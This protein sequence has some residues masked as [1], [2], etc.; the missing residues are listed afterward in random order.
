MNVCIFGLG[1]IGLPIAL[2]CADS[3]HK[4]VGIDVNEILINT[5]KKGEMAFDEPE[6]KELLSK[7]LNKNFFPK[8]Q[9]KDDVSSDLKQAEYIM[10][11]VG[12]GFA[13]YPDKL[14]LS[15][16]Y[17]IVDQITAT[18]VNGKTIILRVTLPIGTSDEIKN[19]I[20]KKTGLKE[21]KDFWFSF[22]PERI[23]EGKAIREERSLPKIVGCYS[24]EGFLKVSTF[25]KK[26][27]G[28]IVRVSNPRTA[29]F[30]KLIDNSWRNTRFAFANE[31]AFLAEENGIDVM[32]AIA[33]A[34]AGYERNEIPRPGPVSGYCLGK[35]PYL[36]E[37]AFEKIAKR[38]GFDSMWYYGRRANDWF[39]EKVVEEVKGKNVL[40]AGLSFKEN[41][42]DYR[43]SHGIEI[44]R[45]LLSKGCKVVVC[46]PFLNKNYY[47]KL[48]EDIANKAKGFNTIEEA[49][50]S[51]IDTV[52]F[53][54]RHQ[55]YQKLDLEKLFKN[56]KISDVTVIDLWNMFTKTSKNITIKRLGNGVR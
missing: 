17:S 31:L 56:K 26:I 36:L 24:D 32:E 46:D 10:L 34:N 3:G 19:L 47:T 35:D 21:G 8:N 16:L 50:T 30:I 28:D 53:T 45:M 39:N 1:R 15:T 55:E 7:H 9:N 5:I 25:F 13:K 29:E 43:Y 40:I 11:A 22:V 42:D 41:I 54:T 18:G 48:P 51:D 20:E 4:V 2:V 52:I 37:L 23:M 38:R 14:R 6:M 44:T 49:L 27:G 33:S 12:T